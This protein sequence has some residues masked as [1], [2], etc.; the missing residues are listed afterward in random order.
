MPDEE[1]PPPVEDRYEY[2]MG[3]PPELSDRCLYWIKRLHD[4]GH[5]DRY[6]WRDIAALLHED[7]DWDGNAEKFGVYLWEWFH[8]IYH[9]VHHMIYEA[10]DRETRPRVDVEAFG[11]AIEAKVTR[12]EVYGDLGASPGIF[13]VK[14]RWE[15]RDV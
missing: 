5:P 3:P 9:T 10:R 12:G 2:W 1:M 15:G 8:I 11:A 13:T 6:D 4:F 14:G 7:N